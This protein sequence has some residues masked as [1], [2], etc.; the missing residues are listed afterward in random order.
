MPVA[1]GAG[2]AELSGTKH[3]AVEGINQLDHLP[4]EIAREFS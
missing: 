4:I 1:A 2:P 3:I